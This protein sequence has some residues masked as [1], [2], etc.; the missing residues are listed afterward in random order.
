ML[1]LNNRNINKKQLQI[2]NIP[3]SQVNVIA[4]PLRYDII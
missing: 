2:L 4:V 1:N 3:D